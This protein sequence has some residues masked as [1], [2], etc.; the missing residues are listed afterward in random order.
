MNKDIIIKHN[1]DDDDDGQIKTLQSI[2]MAM[3]CTSMNNTSCNQSKVVP[4][5]EISTELVSVLTIKIQDSRFKCIYSDIIIVQV[6][7]YHL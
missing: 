5:P 6:Q 3:P 2:V 1:D 4:E 7:I